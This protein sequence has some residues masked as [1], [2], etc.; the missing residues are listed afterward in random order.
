MSLFE[1]SPV[2]A[3]S[4]STTTTSTPQWYQDLTYNQMMAAK[5]VADMPYQQYGMPRV[6]EM[7]PDQLAAQQS[8]R[9]NLGAWEPYYAT[10]LSGTQNLQGPN[11]GYT[12]GMGY[13]SQAANANIPGAAQPYMSAAAQSSAAN[14]GQYMNPYNDAVTS[15]IAK[16]GARNLSENL[17]PQVSDAFIRSGSFGGTRMG[18]FGARALRDTQESILGQ[19]AQA[20]QSGYGQAL[21]A[22]QQDLGRQASLASTAGSLA[23]QQG[24]LLANVG[25]TTGGL[26]QSEAERQLGT[27]Q[28]YADMARTGQGMYAQDAAALTAV[29]Q[30]QQAQKQKQ[31]DAAYQNYMDQLQYP[32]RQLDW[33]Q[34]QLRGSGQYLPTTANQSGY[35]TSPGVSPLSQLASGYFALRGMGS[36]GSG[37]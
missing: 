15:Q 18:E 21:S 9:Q 17:L 2:T 31:L 32:Q 20:L 5:A 16:M 28:S 8:V 37:A 24:S 23:G 14:V 25:Q 29:G 3:P 35:T 22:A 6:A 12:Q 4:E 36:A 33:Y 10:A 13:L 7:T 27:L 34:A 1:G 26:G 11:A 30:E 19:Q